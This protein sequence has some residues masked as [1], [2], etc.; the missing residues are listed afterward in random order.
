MANIIASLAV[1]FSGLTE[2]SATFVTWFDEPECPK[3]LL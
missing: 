1:F 3:E 2:T